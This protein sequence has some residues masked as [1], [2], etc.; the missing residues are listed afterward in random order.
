M[1]K[2]VDRAPGR[3]AANQDFD[4]LYRKFLKL[5]Y[6]EG[7]RERAEPVAQ[8]LEKALADSPE[9]ADSIRGEEVRSLIAELRG[10]F[11]EAARCREAEIRKILELHNLAVNTPNWEYVAGQYDF[12]DV[13]DRLDLLAIL[14]DKQGELD[15]AI[16]TLEESKRYCQSHGIPF[17]G[18]DVLD[19]LARAVVPA[20]R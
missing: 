9:L 5:F 18:Q 16:S 11:A 19:E 12:G 17:G 8:R 3:V 2:K 13:S 10:G 15:R 1:A 7:N 20:R 14:Y 6:E 4:S